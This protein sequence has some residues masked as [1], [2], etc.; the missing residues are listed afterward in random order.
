MEY[1]LCLILST[2][3]LVALLQ[4]L[5]RYDLLFT[6]SSTVHQFST[7]LFV[8]VNTAQAVVDQ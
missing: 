3:T 4:L 1:M 2:L 5:L 7:S 8:A 6:P